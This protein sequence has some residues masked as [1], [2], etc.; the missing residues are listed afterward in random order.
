VE[1][2]HLLEPWGVLAKTAEALFLVVYGFE[3]T[4]FG[5]RALVGCLATVLVV[6]LAGAALILIGGEPTHHKK[7]APSQQHDS[8]KHAE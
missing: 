7:V 5:R 1:E 4:W 8:K 6:A 3:L 2:G